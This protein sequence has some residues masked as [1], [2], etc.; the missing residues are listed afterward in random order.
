MQK[1]TKV[2]KRCNIEKELD[3]F[4]SI[5]RGSDVRFRDYS[6][7]Y[8]GKCKRCKADEAKAYRDS[9]P[10]LWKKYRESSKLKKLEEKEPKELQLLKSAI[11]TRRVEAKGRHKKKHSTE[12]VSKDYL[13]KLWN[14]QNGLCVFSGVKMSLVRKTKDT[15][16]LDQIIAGDGYVEGNVQWVTWAVNRAKRDMSTDDFI[17]MC[18]LVVGNFNDYRKPP[19]ESE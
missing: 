12:V 3:L 17:N 19:S 8:G 11:A 10:N 15:L 13:L 7:S 6:K 2:C 16:S 1:E 9:R 18:K 14:N 4:P 5:V